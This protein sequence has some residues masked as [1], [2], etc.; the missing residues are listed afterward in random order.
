MSSKQLLSTTQEQ[1]RALS[2][3][4]KVIMKWLG[5]HYINYILDPWP[6]NSKDLN[7]IENLR[8]ILKKRVDKQKPTIRQKGISISQDFAQ[9]LIS[10]MPE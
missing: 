5:D 7:P 4:A 8:S 2:S 6:G 10:N 9:K 3:E 1:F